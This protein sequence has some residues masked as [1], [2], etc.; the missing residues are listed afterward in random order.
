M[1]HL[2]VL[3]ETNKKKSNILKLINLWNELSDVKLIK[4]WSLNWII[5]N[6]NEVFSRTLDWFTCVQVNHPGWFSDR[7]TQNKSFTK[8]K[9]QYLTLNP[10]TRPNVSLLCLKTIIVKHNQTVCS[11]PYLCDLPACT[12]AEVLFKTWHA[13]CFI[14]LCGIHYTSSHHQDDNRPLISVMKAISLTIC[15]TQTSWRYQ[16][17]QYTKN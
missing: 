8:Q 4:W 5:S 11:P 3:F 13:V 7:I 1:N 17:A 6:S 16:S 15:W 12:A 14:V 2:C 10:P 9:S